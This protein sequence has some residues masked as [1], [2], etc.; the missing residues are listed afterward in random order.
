[1]N[2]PGPAAGA[3][4]ADYEPCPSCGQ[5][6]RVGSRYCVYCGQPT[7]WAD[8]GASAWASQPGA[9]FRLSLWR[10][11]TSCGRSL[12]S[13]N[14][15]CIYCGQPGPSVISQINQRAML[16]G[17]LGA[18]TTLALLFVAILAWERVNV[19]P[20]PQPA[21]APTIEASTAYLVAAQSSPVFTVTA[22]P[23]GLPSAMP[24]PPSPVPTAPPTATSTPSPT[25]V[26]ARTVSDVVRESRPFTVQIK[27]SLGVG[28]GSTG[29]GI[30]VANNGIVITNQHVIEGAR[31][32]LVIIE[33]LGEIPAT[34]VAS[35]AQLDLAILRIDSNQKPPVAPLGDSEALVLGEDVIVLGY[36]LSGGQTGIS[37]SVTRGVVSKRIPMSQ[38][39]YQYIQTDAAVNPGNS[40]G[41]L[42]NMR[43]EVVGIV[44][45][46]QTSSGGVPVEGVGIAIPS[47]AVKDYL[48]KNR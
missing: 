39:Q 3:P 1:M 21:P 29:T 16:L 31:N 4:G 11:C 35:D 25:V 20:N 41:P 5:L 32:V 10:R 2:Y 26:P 34:V 22:P 8:V 46:K 30:V 13:R 23:S 7:P 48:A 9:R 44:T 45:K 37:P 33:G 12:P 43:A 14:R 17:G 19:T 24:V 15:F 38:Y 28:G 6:S 40:G 47:T 36:P 18:A 27:A 42:I